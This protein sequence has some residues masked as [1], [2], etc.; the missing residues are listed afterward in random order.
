VFTKQQSFCNNEKTSR[1]FSWIAVKQHSSRSYYIAFTYYSAAS[2]KG[3]H[4][5]FINK[6]P[7]SIHQVPYYVMQPS[8]CSREF[9]KMLLS[10]I[11]QV[12]SMQHCHRESTVVCSIHQVSMQ[13][14][15]SCH[16]HTYQVLVFIVEHAFS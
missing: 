12:N 15:Q 13:N 6:L 5:A 16:E 8:S 10:S 1:S 2:S 9:S 14:H 3:C 7:N 11:N 4:A